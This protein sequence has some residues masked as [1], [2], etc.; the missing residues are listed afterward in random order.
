MTA[1]GNICRVRGAWSRGS[2]AP[3]PVLD[4]PHG[5]AMPAKLMWL[6]KPV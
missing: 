4:L 3:E 1:T 2:S 6:P 5:R